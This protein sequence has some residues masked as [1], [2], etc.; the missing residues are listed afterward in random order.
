MDIS[1]IPPELSN[2]SD[3]EERLLSRIVQFLKIIKVQ[4]RFSQNWCKGQVILFAQ[5]IIELA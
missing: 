1:Q 4:N 2:L 5:D 3:I